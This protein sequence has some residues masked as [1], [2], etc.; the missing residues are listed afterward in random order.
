[1]AQALTRHDAILQQAI[2]A[3]GGIVFKTVGDTVHAVFTA[4]PDALAAALATQHALHRESWGI[5]GPLR[6]RMAIHTGAADMRDGDYFGLPLNRIARM[7]AA[8]HGGRILGR[9]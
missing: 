6:V 3:S 4:A 1:M 9:L 5:T 7:L 2:A 8:G